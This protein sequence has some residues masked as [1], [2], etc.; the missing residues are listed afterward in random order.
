L[1]QVQGVLV[2]KRS[3]AEQENISL[4][5]KFD[6]EKAQLHQEKEQFLMEKLKVKEAVNRAFCFVT[7]L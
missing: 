1:T 4:Q 7:V 3:A 2:E 6:E 5:A